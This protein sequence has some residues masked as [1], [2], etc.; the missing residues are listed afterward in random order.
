VQ[1][2]WPIYVQ[3]CSQEFGNTTRG[4]TEALETAGVNW[5]G[6]I[7]VPGI[8]HWPGTIVANTVLSQPAGLVD[9]HPTICGLL[10]L[11]K[12]PGVFLDGS[13]LSTLLVGKPETFVRH[14]PLFWH[15]QKSRPIVAMRDGD[16]SLVANPDFTLSTNNMFEE[17]WIP[18]IKAGAYKE[19][20]L[21]NLTTDRSQQHDL[22]QEMPEKVAE[23]KEKLLRINASIMADGA[24]WHQP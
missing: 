9:I 16:W 13:D 19:Y 4:T 7:S 22:A 2:C 14:Q 15:L 18:V 23:L 1:T 12:P 21:L 17:A 8:F 10:G 6:G 3:K 5:E 20:Q 11:E 24:D